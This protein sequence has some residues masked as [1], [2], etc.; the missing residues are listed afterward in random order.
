MTDAVARLFFHDART[1]RQQALVNLSPGANPGD[2]V[3]VFQLA[4]SVDGRRLAVAQY[5]KRQPRV[6]VLDTGIRRDTVFVPFH[7]GGAACINELTSDALD[8][9]SRMPA[10]KAC[11]VAVD[12]KVWASAGR[13]RQTWRWWVER[14][15]GSK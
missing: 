13:L 3:E 10:F 2:P 12:S 9:T 5:G 14:P 15:I 6:T 8:P 7:W 1:R 4:Y 11:P